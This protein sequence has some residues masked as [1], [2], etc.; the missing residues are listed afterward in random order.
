MT[1]NRQDIK[2]VRAEVQESKQEL[3]LAQNAGDVA[4]VDF[5]RKRLLQLESQ[6]SYLHEQQTILLRS[7]QQILPVQSLTSIAALKDRQAHQPP[8]L[9]A[10]EQAADQVVDSL[11]SHGYGW[12]KVSEAET[13]SFHELQQYTLPGSCFDEAGDLLRD[14]RLLEYITACPNPS[15]PSAMCTA[16]NKVGTADLEQAMLVKSWY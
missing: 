13:Q 11:Q 10:N 6:L 2:Y 15:L 12:L 8:L 7:R 1:A 4:Q 3:A 16:A 14:K 5:H 9:D